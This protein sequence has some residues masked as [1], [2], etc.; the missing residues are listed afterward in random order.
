MRLILLL[1]T[2]ALL[3]HAVPQSNGIEIQ[4]LKGKITLDGVVDEQAWQSIKPFPLISHWPSFGNQP[5][6]PTEIK[7]TYDE[8]Y[9]YVAG[10]MEIDPEDMLIASFKRDI[11][12]MGSDYLTIILDTFNDNENALHFSTTPTGSR[13]DVAISDDTKNIDESWDTFWETEAFYDDQGWS[14]EMRIPFSSMGFQ[15]NNGSVEMGLMVMMYSAKKYELVS[16]PA[17]EPNWGFWS[18]AKPSQFQKVTFK[19]IKSHNP[20]YITPYILGGFA[21]QNDLNDEETS[22]KKSDKISKNIGLDVRYNVTNNLTLDFSVNTDFAQVEAD[23]QQVNLTRFSLFF[24]EKRRFFLERANIFDFGFSGFNRLFYT[25]NIGLNDGENVDILGG[26]RLTGRVNEWDVGLLNV[27]TGKEGDLKAENFGVARLK[28]QVLNP[29]SYVGGMVTNRIDEN[30]SF[31]LGVGLDGLFNL[32]E[33]D[34]LSFSLVQTHTDSVD[35]DVNFSKASRLRLRWERRSYTGFAYDFSAERVAE[36]YNPAMGFE[37]R[38]DFSHFNSRFSYGWADKDDTDLQRH[39]FVIDADVYTRNKDN[40]VETIEIK[41]FW[42]G[43]LLSGSFVERGIILSHEKIDESFDL[44]DS[45]SIEAGEYDFAS[46]YTTLSTPGGRNFSSEEFFSIGSYYD[47][48][49][50]S[51]GITPKWIASKYLE[52]TVNYEYNYIDFNK[53]DQSFKSHSSKLKG[54]FSLNTKLSLS[55]FLQYNSNQDIIFSNVRFRYNPSEGNDLYVV[56]NELF[57]ANRRS[58]NPIRPLTKNRTILAKYTYTFTY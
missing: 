21:V 13:T 19:K 55:A 11:F 8:K 4:P 18:W 34:Y 45:V 49:I 47:G 32:Y 50:F 3:I 48:T 22:Y 14:A 6:M 9:I 27:Q 36:N 12:T 7:V 33:N 20:V 10:K 17:I 51:F 25:R 15:D 40:S 58:Y 54:L 39:R 56:Y 30:G 24:P 5:T 28:R 42:E 38:E 53:R 37:L 16:Y 44:S 29:F 52:L 43:A 35:N 46:F 57:N 41:P 31:N 23:D 26:V 1:L 2:N